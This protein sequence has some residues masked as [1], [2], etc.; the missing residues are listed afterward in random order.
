MTTE[1]K[2]QEN[3]KMEARVSAKINQELKDKLSERAENLGIYEADIIREALQAYLSGF[4]GHIDDYDK[5][6]KSLASKASQISGEAISTI[7]NRGLKAESKRIISSHEKLQNQISEGEEIAKTTKG[8]AFIRIEMAVQDVYLELK[9]KIESNSKLSKHDHITESKIFK[10]CG[11]NRQS[12][13]KYFD[14]HFES[15][16]QLERELGLNPS[17]NVGLA[18]RGIKE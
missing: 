17:E 15:I 6:V 18:K 7:A 10:N 12:I 16:A 14:T 8:S 13:G 1:N 5:E 2:K 11:S 3:S 4:D 9:A